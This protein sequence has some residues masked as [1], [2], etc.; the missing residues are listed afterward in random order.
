MITSLLLDKIDTGTNYLIQTP[1]F[2]INH[3][4]LNVSKLPS[5]IS[6]Q[7]IST[8]K[9]PSFCD[10]TNNDIDCENKISLLKVINFILLL[11]FILLFFDALSDDPVFSNPICFFF[12]CK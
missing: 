9:L 2:I 8:F 1:S 5:Q 10:L 12:E 3:M 6:I 11:N 7:N 4:L